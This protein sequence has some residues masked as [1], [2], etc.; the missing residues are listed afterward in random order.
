MGT[1]RE[2]HLLEE[3]AKRDAI[4]EELRAE[5][6]LLRQKVDLLIRKV[7]GASSERIDRRRSICFWSNRRT[8]RENR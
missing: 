6:A 7:F 3:I 8:R 4:I 5:N 2:K 1:A